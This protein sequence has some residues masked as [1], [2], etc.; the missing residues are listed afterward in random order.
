MRSPGQVWVKNNRSAWNPVRC[1]PGYYERSCGTNRISPDIWT[2]QA[3]AVHGDLAAAACTFS[4]TRAACPRMTLM[5]CS[6][7]AVIPKPMS[8]SLRV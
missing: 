5:T 2:R 8:I 4:Y 6:D 7:E 3:Y 1:C